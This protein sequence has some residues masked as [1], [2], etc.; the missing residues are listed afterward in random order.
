MKTEW[1][2]AIETATYSRLLKTRERLE[3]ELKRREQQLYE[4]NRE[5]ERREE[6]RRAA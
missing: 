2:L 1:Q 3:E 6:K 4:L 5:I